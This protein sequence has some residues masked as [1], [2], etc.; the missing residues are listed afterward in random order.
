MV[1]INSNEAQKRQSDLNWELYYQTCIHWLSYGRRTNCLKKRGIYYFDYLK[2]GNQKK[3][4]FSFMFKWITSLRQPN[5][6][7]LKES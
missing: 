7:L 6:A 2:V 4:K 3:K 1:P 5:A